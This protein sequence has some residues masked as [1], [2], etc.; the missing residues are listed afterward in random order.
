MKIRAGSWQMLSNQEKLFLLNAISNRPQT[1]S[2]GE[3]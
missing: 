1:K 2:R 3:H